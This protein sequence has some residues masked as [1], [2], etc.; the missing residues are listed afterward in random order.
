M[1]QEITIKKSYLFLFIAFLFLALVFYFLNKS[2]SQN[3][4]NAGN[5]QEVYLSA[6]NQGYDTSYIMVKKDIPVRFHFKATDAGCGNYLVI[7]GLN[8]TI[9]SVNGA[10]GVVEFTPKKEGTYQFNCPMMMLDSGKFVVSS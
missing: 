2:P 3:S 8:V 9:P 10:E 7:Y 5:F 4:I 6:T 1:V